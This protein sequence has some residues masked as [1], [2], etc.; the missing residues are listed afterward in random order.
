MDYTGNTQREH[1]GIDFGTTNISATGLIID[2]AL[3]KSFRVQYGEDGV[4]FPSVMSIAPKNEEGIFPVKFGRKV[5][6]SA[7]ILEEQ[8]EVIIKSIKTETANPDKIFDLFGQQ[9]KPAAIIGGLM[10]E[11][12]RFIMKY[13]K[14][15]IEIKEATIAVPVDFSKSQRAIII[16]AFQKAGIKVNKIISESTA[17]YIS[18]RKSVEYLSNVM[19][20]DWGGGTLDISLLNVDKPQGRIY[21]LATAGWSFAGDKID[22]IIAQYIHEQLVKSEEYDIRISYKELP[23]KDKLKVLTE[24]ERVKINFGDE[25]ETEEPQKVFMNDYCGEKKVFCDFT[26][27]TFCALLKKTIGDAV[28]LIQTVLEKAELS[29]EALGAIIMVGGSSNL[30]PLREF[31]EDELAAKHKVKVVY[32]DKPQWSVS[33]GAAIIDSLDCGYALNQDISLALSDGTAFQIL[34]KG[35]KIPIAEQ[36]VS[37]GTIDNSESANFIFCDDKE[38]LL[39]RES[40]NSKGY[41]GERYYV[42]AQVDNDLVAQITLYSEYRMAGVQEKK[43]EIRSLSFYYDIAQI[44]QYITEDF[45]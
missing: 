10:K 12:T 6:S 42:K 20:F 19:V 13:D 5:K 3:K 26:Y 45:G 15:P 32:P 17:A 29:V 27:E 4:P 30:L 41:D 18:N 33:E 25:D 35:M 39:L 37:F 14:H 11:I 34:K 8:G 7:A 16:E 43:L 40:L 22:E 38:N 2:S 28:K 31:L 1:I 23:P 9:F 21:E 24:A 36:A 44:D